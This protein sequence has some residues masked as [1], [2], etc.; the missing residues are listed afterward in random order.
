M[1]DLSALTREEL[2]SCLELG[3]TITAELESERLFTQILMR[4][5]ELLPAEHWSLLLH[6]E[7]TGELRFEIAVGLDLGRVKDIRLARGEGIAGWVALQ[8][9]PTVIQDVR[10]CDFFSDKVDR[11]SGVNTRSVVCVPLI[12]GGRCLGVI[13]VV[14][15]RNL[16]GSA[17]ALLSVIS[18]YAAIAVENMLRYRNVQELTIRD[19]LTGLFNTRYLYEALPRLISSSDA[20]GEPLSLI[21][22]DIDDFKHVVDGY[23]HLMGSRA[24]QEVAQTIKGCLAWPAFAVAYG[25]DEFVAVL[26]NFDKGRAR[27]KAQEIRVQ[28]F[29]TLYLT[30]EGHDVRLRAS[31]GLATYPGDAADMKGILARADQAMF[32]VKRHVKGEVR[33]A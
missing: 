23:G 3:K 22:M 9:A 7:K 29:K 31:F 24:L 21:F 27:K 12:F 6:D 26:P 4:L 14:N 8:K 2:L 1:D 19:N 32:H 28:M 20:G 18:D 17:L 5:S 11:V 13:E 16:G 25:G 15:P 10:Q 30:E 33:S